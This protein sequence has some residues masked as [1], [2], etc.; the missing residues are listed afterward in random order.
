M[1]RPSNHYD[2]LDRNLVRFFV[3]AGAHPGEAVGM[4]SAHGDKCY[5]YR[6]GWRLAGISFEHGVAMYLLTYT[7]MYSSQVRQTAR[8]W[9]PPYDWVI[10]NYDGFKERLAQ[11]ESPVQD[12]PTVVG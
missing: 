12:G 8:G 7:Q 6:E 9:M 1:M 2:W 10:L 5:T 3:L 4:A 11:A